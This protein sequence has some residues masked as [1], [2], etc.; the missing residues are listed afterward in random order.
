MRIRT[1][2]MAALTAVLLAGCAPGSSSTPLPTPDSRQ[3]DTVQGTATFDVP[4]GWRAVS[5]G[6]ATILQP[7]VADTN[8]VRITVLESRKGAKGFESAAR[9]TRADARED[10]DSAR[11][12]ADRTFDDQKWFTVSSTVESDDGTTE[13]LAYGTVTGGYRLLV[14]LE[15]DGVDDSTALDARDTLRELMQSVR[16]TG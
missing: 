10:D 3:T 14:Q 13:R 5:E 2:V 12:G 1:I 7:R 6:S 8:Q 4:R 16:L 9:L 11:F 15:T